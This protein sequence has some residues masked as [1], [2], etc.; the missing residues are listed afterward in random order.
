[1]A[2]VY[3]PTPKQLHYVRTTP[4]FIPQG[5]THLCWAASLQSW[6][7]VTVRE[8]GETSGTWSGPEAEKNF[9]NG[10]PWKRERLELKDM[11]NRWGDLLNDDKSLVPENMPKIALDIGMTGSVLKAP[12]LLAPSL[13]EKIRSSCLYMIYFSVMMNHAIVVYGFTTPGSLDVMDPNPT[14]GLIT[15]PLSFFN[16]PGRIDRTMFIGW[17]LQ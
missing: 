16:E 15:R 10:L 9:F 13:F 12:Q 14:Q 6:L 3:V 11:V 7:D 2:N 1:M 5:D 4:Q 17:A 8:F